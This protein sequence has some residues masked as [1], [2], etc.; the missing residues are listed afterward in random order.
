MLESP[1]LEVKLSPAELDRQCLDLYQSMSKGAGGDVLRLIGGGQEVGMQSLYMQNQALKERLS[2]GGTVNGTM[3]F[4]VDMEVE[5]TKKEDR[6]ASQWV[7]WTMKQNL[8]NTHANYHLTAPPPPKTMKQSRISNKEDLVGNSNTQSGSSSS[9]KMSLQHSI[10][11]RDLGLSRTMR[12]DDWS[13][14]RIPP[15]SDQSSKRAMQLSSRG[16][17]RV[18]LLI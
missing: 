15:S 2:S 11:R 9:L 12:S 18:S 7:S 17:L 8:K 4:F 10:S 6:T 1:K 13:S 16:S 3:P 14:M 5:Q